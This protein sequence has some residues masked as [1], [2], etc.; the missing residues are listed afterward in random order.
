MAEEKKKRDR[1]AK[2]GQEGYF[3]R[4]TAA[5]TAAAAQEH[6]VFASAEEFTAAAEAYFADADAN[7]ELYGEA[8]LCLALSRLNK[9]RRNVTLGTLRKWYD[10]DACKYLQDAVQ[11]AYLRIQ[12]Q[13]ETDERYA[14]KGGMATRAIFLQ[15]QK[16]F[17]GYQDKTETKNDMNLNIT[18]GRNMDKSDFE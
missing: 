5:A 17:G 18:F 7:G 11:M 8:G 12:R 10:G 4:N 9:K 15:K 14:E 6:A 1:Y 13:I 16:R 3:E 2:K